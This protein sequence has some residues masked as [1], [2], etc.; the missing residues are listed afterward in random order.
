MFRSVF[1]LSF[2]E[3]TQFVLPLDTHWKLNVHNTF[4]NTSELHIQSYAL[5]L[6]G[7][8]LRISH[9]FYYVQ[10]KVETCSTL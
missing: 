5:C 2:L 7:V 3:Q 10:Q 4:N 6:G 1:I 8:K 9:H